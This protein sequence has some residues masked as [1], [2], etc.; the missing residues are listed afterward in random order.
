[1]SVHYI[2]RWW[3]PDKKE[4]CKSTLGKEPTEDEA[5]KQLARDVNYFY[6]DIAIELVRVEMTTLETVTGGG[7]S[8][9]KGE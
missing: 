2:V 7:G 4:W 6:G 1:M 9:K 3:H 5:R 8:R